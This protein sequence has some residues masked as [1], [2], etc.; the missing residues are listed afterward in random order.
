MSVIHG[1]S[2]PGAKAASPTVPGY[3]DITTNVPFLLEEATF[4]ETLNNSLE[5]V[6]SNKTHGHSMSF[7]QVRFHFIVSVSIHQ[8]I[9]LYFRFH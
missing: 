1:E 6:E 9:P 7:Y 3:E 5:N 8:Y 2:V 4:M